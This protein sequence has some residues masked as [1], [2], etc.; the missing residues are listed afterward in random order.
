[1]KQRKWLMPVHAFALLP[2]G[3]LVL[4]LAGCTSTPKPVAWNLEITARTPDSGRLDLIGIRR[5]DK[6]EWDAVVVNDY[7]KADNAL[8]KNAPRLSFEIVDGKINLPEPK[9]AGDTNK[10]SGL[11]TSKVTIAKNQALVKKWMDQGAAGL[12]LIGQF[13]RDS[14][15]GPDPRKRIWPLYKGS[16]DAVKSTLQFEIQDGRIAVITRESPKA[17]PF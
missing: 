6:P 13:R 8:R 2:A 4:L 10:I 3:A 11:G 9:G 14:A 16:W 7:W 17:P 12:V 15:D 5:L 1:M